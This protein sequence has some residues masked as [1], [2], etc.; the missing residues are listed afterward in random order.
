[1]PRVLLIQGANMAYLGKRQPEIYGTTT[2]AELDALL[3]EQAKQAGCDLEI[4]YT[5]V[6]GEAIGRIYQAVEEGVEGIMMNPAGFSYA[7]YALRDCLNAVTVPYVEVHMTNVERRGIH[8]V[9][10]QRADGVVF[11]LGV[12]SYV[13][14]LQALLHLIAERK[15]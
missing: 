6:E 12:Q 1:M 13:L 8:S 9:I 11:G 4:L 5:H 3:Q 10:V 15:A 7:G 2:A 14:G